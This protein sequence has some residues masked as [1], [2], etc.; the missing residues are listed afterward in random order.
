MLDKP[1]VEKREKAQIIKIRNGNRK[2]HNQHHIQRITR[3]NYE[4]FHANDMETQKKWTS[5]WKCT[6]SQD[7]PTAVGR[8]KEIKAVQIG[9]EEVELLLFA[10]D[11]IFYIETLKMPWKDR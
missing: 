7:R 2:S 8:E 11:M 1:V 9:K 4:Q 5:F 6:V 3:D 10:N